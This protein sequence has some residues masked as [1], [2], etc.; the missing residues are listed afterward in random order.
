[1]DLAFVDEGGTLAVAT[2]TADGGGELALWKIKADKK[3]GLIKKKEWYV[4]LEAPPVR[5]AAS[6]DNR[7]LAIGLAGGLVQI[8]EVDSKTVVRTAELD[9]MLRDMVWCDPMAPGPLLP[10][11]SDDEPPALNL[12]G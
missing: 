8:V 6:P 10:D 4:A 3:K 11:W 7:H 5:L 2:A 1:M 12:G 9:G